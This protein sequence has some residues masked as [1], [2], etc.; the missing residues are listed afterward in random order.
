[1]VY[2]KNLSHVGFG[3]NPASGSD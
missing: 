2:Q 1:V 3:E